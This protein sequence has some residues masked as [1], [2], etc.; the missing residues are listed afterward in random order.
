MRAHGRSLPA[1]GH[2]PGHIPGPP[3]LSS[4]PNGSPI[5]VIAPGSRHYSKQAQIDD[6]NAVHAACGLGGGSGSGGPVVLVGHSMGGH[7]QMLFQSVS[8]HT[9]TRT[10]TRTRTRTHRPT[11]PQTHRPTNLNLDPHPGTPTGPSTH[12]PAHEPL[13]AGCLP[14][15]PAGRQARYTVPLSRCPAAML[16]VQPDGADPIM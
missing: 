1:P 15:P 6:F 7:D 16:S 4:D 5:A 11:D 3:P 13:C 8:A 10:R 12:P 14:C 9:H 2:I